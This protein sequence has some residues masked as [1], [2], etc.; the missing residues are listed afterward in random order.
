MHVLK[1]IL[2]LALVLAVA[3]G[4]AA[5][6]GPQRDRYP[7]RGRDSRYRDRG[8]D[9]RDYERRFLQPVTDVQRD[10]ERLQRQRDLSD[11]DRRKAASGLHNIERFM[12]NWREG[13]WDKD[14]LDGLIEDL[15]DL[16]RSDRLRA[17]ERATFARNRDE[18][19]AFRARGDYR[20]R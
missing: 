1:L 7:D 4:A 18:M 8:R 20:R 3:A 5:Q 11:R 14:R 19:R 10:L 9:S 12:V 2:P 15:D 16:A 6:P 17:R 13:R